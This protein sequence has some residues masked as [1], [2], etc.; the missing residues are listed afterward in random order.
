MSPWYWW[1]DVPV[2]KQQ[3]LYVIP[4]THVDYGPAVKYRGIFIN[5]EAPSFASWAK[6]K[7]GGVNHLLYAKMFELILR[8]K[9]NYLWPAMWDNAFNDD[10][11][12]DPE[13]AD[14]YGIVMGTSHHEPMNRAQQEWKRYGSGLWNYEANA[15]TIRSFWRKGIEHMGNNET[16]ITIGMR[17]DGDK[18][19][20]E[21]SNITL[22]EKIVTDQRVIIQD[23]THK[24]ASKTPQVWALYKEVQ[25]YY[26]KGMRVPDDVTLLLCDD[27]W[28]NLRKLPKLNEPARKGGYGIYYHFDYV[29]DPRNYK[30]LNTNPISKTWEQMHL[31][32]EYSARQLW[33]VNVG[34]L[35]PME[36]PISFFLDY[37]WSPERWPANRLG[38][39]TRKWAAQQFGNTHAD[40]IADILTTY[41]KYNARCKPELLNANTYSLIN[42]R[43]FEQVVND[44]K[45]LNIKAK[46]LYNILLKQYKD[47]YYQLVLHPVEACANLNEMYFD[48]AKNKLYSTQGRAATNLMANDVKGLFIRDSDISHY[49]NKI[50]ANGKWDHMM[51]QTRIG[52]ANWQEPPVNKIPAVQTIKLPVKSQMGIA[53]EGSASWW[54]NAVGEP[55]LPGFYYGCGSHYIEVFNRGQGSIQF[56]VSCTSPYL[57]IGIKKGNTSL[58]QRIWIDVNWLKVP[59]GITDVP[60]TVIGSDNRKVTVHATIRN[61]LPLSNFGF[62]EN[63]GYVSMEAAHY[64]KA[65]NANYIKWQVI[66]DYGRSL[67]G[68]MPIPVTANSQIPGGNAPHLEYKIN[69]IDTGWLNL[70]IYIS[71]TLDF[72]NSGG[73]KI[74]ISIDDQKPEIMNVNVDESMKAWGQNVSDNIKVIQT[75]L[76]IKNNG[77]HSLNYWMVNPGIVLQK[78]V[79]E[80]SEDTFSY[81]GPPE[82]Y[83]R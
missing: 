34:D 44:Y 76:H 23:I 40:N 21:V 27:N 71:P 33:I 28:G 5:D 13:L 14:E 43:E 17:G 60:I 39:Y 32:Y 74:A 81:L 10:D 61:V 1:A 80:S 35:K 8:L 67:S 68:L 70:K 25:D 2:K 11:K 77:A 12:L 49:Y 55:V 9:G 48:V 53:V 78:I 24:D 22:L 64:S 65:V 20:T 16:I 75:K 58:Q 51:D 37:A 83:H 31:A 46:R 7:F 72:T 56:I 47:A 57:N 69:M 62:N 4:G 15:D 38:E 59:K 66:P 18:P 26:D 45:K 29:G 41:T 42:Y 36:F 82:S 19:M 54:P 3:N 73:L 50:M 63:N 79:I 6:A 30:W 52:Y